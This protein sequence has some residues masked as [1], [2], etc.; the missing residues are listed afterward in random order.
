MFDAHCHLYVPQF[1][2]DEIRQLSADAASVGVRAIV[3]VPESIDDMHEVL[4]LAAEN[5]MIAPCAGLHPVQPAHTDGAPYSGQ[6]CVSM[7]DL[8]AALDF[9]RQHADD[10]VAVGE[11]MLEVGLDF[12]PHVLNGDEGLKEVQRAVFG[13]QIDLAN[14]LGLPLN[15]HSRSAGHHAIDLLLER[16]VQQA[17][18]LHAFDGRAVHA[19]RAIERCPHV[20]FSVPPSIVRSPQKQ[21]L[22][23]ALPLDRLLLETDA[24]ALGP[25]RG[26]RNRPSNITAARD[27]VSG[28]KGVAP[29]EVERA[30]TANALRAFPRLAR[31]AA[32]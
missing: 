10:L 17:V 11:V 3:T 19:L 25:T 7:S 32:G 8:P 2:Q 28:I 1:S 16:Q 27:A 22:V 12:S 15:V 21:K 4:R 31:W 6:R 9:I 29:G 30:T 26:E 14:N 23:A 13:A 18:L 5:H 24:P 20:Y